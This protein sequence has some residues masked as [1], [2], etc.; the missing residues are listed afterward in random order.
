MILWAKPIASR[1]EQQSYKNCFLW[2]QSDGQLGETLARVRGGLGEIP[3]TH[4]PPE[5]II[6]GCRDVLGELRPSGMCRVQT[7]SVVLCRAMLKTP[8]DAARPTMQIFVK[9]NEG[10][11][12]TL[13][14][15]ASDTIDDVKASW[16][17]RASLEPP[18][19]PL[20]LVGAWAN[21]S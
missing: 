3:G 13:D 11:T 12:I 7:T 6:V 9:I 4:M 21:A 18:L 19:G 17:N 16:A 20:G 14:V 8:T 10:T 1:V 5:I 2:Q 15:K